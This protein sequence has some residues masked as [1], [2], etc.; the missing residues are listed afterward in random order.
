M[1][2]VADWETYDDQTS[3]DGFSELEYTALSG[4]KVRVPIGEDLAAQAAE[5]YRCNG[6]DTVII[7]YRPA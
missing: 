1:S 2:T 4:N 6:V 3:A 5:I 7:L